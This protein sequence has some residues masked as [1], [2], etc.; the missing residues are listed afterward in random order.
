MITVQFPATATG[1]GL[2]SLDVKTDPGTKL[3]RWCESEKKFKTK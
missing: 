2:E 3:N 1:Y